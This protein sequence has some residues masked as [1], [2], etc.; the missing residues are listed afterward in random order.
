MRGRGLTVRDRIVV[1]LSGFTRFS[2]DYECPEEMCQSG[3]SKAVGKSRAHVTLELNRMVRDDIVSERST[4]IK[5]ARTKRKAYCLTANGLARNAK[6]NRHLETLI[7]NVT[8]PDCN[9]P[10][11]GTE[12][13]AYLVKSCAMTQACATETVIASD[14]FLVLPKKASTT[15]IIFIP[16]RQEL[17]IPR[18]EL[19]DLS[20]LLSGKRPNTIVLLGI[21]GTGKTSLL[22]ELAWTIGGEMSVFYTRL[23]PYESVQ[24]LLQRLGDFLGNS[25]FRTLSDMK[26]VGNLMSQCLG[27]HKFALLFDEYDAASESLNPFFEMLAASVCGT[28]SGMV[29]A[30]DRKPGF[31]SMKHLVLDKSVTEMHIGGLDPEASLKLYRKSGGC[32]GKPDIARAGGHPLLIKFLASGIGAGTLIEYV[33]SEILDNDSELARACRFASVLRKP[34]PA[35]DLEL[36]GVAPASTARRNLAFEEQHSGGYMLHPAISGI[37]SSVAG[38]RMLGSLHSKAASYY[39]IAGTGPQEALYH[40][41]ASGDKAQARVF[42]AGHAK[43]L[44]GTDNPGELA[45]LIQSFITPDDESLVLLETASIACDKAGFDSALSF[46]ESI[47]TKAPDSPEAQRARVLSAKIL[48]KKGRLSEGL[49]RLRGKMPHD[50]VQAGQWHYAKATILRR[51]G[52]LKPALAEC[53]CAEAASAECG[54]RGLKA[55]CWMESAMILSALGDNERALGRLSVA[56]SEFA[57]IG[58]A[59]DCI[60]CGINMGIVLRTL[61]REREASDALE[62]AVAKADMTGRNRLRA[63]ALANLTEVLNIMGRHERSAELANQAIQIFSALGEPVFLAACRFNLGTALAHLGR[64]DDAVREFEDAAALLKAHGMLGSRRQ[65]VLDAA[66][67]LEGLGRKK[68][69]TGFRKMIE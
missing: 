13:V 69:A 2:E 49:G 31:Y 61:G 41:L 34:F 57:E 55:E 24:S 42:I 63:Q 29:V 22:N 20:G 50:P 59:D 48:A 5:G 65:W 14:G 39:M 40:L 43:D 37:M 7:L 44:A 56:M 35:D 51:M 12:A 54:N 15:G 45:R 4:R 18:K 67:L 19:G 8:G 33:E 10:M 25:S 16:P 23:Y 1:H 27:R 3:I 53:E 58:N 9:G 21:S 28:G 62:T 26:E 52:R 17:F 11:S 32:G 47:I 60:R 46:S 36:I 30:S 64:K 66:E 68:A 38:D 6:I